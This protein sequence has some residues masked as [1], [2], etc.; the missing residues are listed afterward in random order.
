ME[1]TIKGDALKTFLGLART[2]EQVARTIARQWIQE[3]EPD[4]L[5]AYLLYSTEVAA[6]LLAERFTRDPEGT[7][8]AMSKLPARTSPL[9]AQRGRPAGQPAAAGKAR[10]PG[11]KRGRRRK[12]RRYSAAEIAAL[13][14]QIVAF[15]AR[16]PG[17]TRKQLH[18]AIEFPSLAIYHRVM[19]ELRDAKLISAKGDRSKTTYTARKAPG[20]PKK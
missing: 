1:L 10:A 14:Q 7:M 19:G 4:A 18:D 20:R 12:R 6:G 8:A 3:V 2:D 15:I 9:P 5:N 11:R 16:R 13:K 17:T